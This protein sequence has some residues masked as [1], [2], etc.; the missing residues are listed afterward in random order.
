[1]ATHKSITV[2]GLRNPN[3]DMQKKMGAVYTYSGIYEA[4]VVSA[5]DIQKNGRLKVRLVDSNVN[6][7][8]IPDK[9]TGGEEFLDITVQWSSPFA[10]A[11][12]VEN[13][14]ATGEGVGDEKDPDKAFGGTQKSYGMWMIPPDVGNKVLV[15]FVNGDL[16]RGFVIGCLY[17]S[18]M[19]HMVP[20]IA[21]SKTFTSDDSQTL[22]VPVAEYN[23]ASD[24]ANSVDWKTVRENDGQTPTDNVRRPTHTEH[25]N[26]LKE[27]GL[28]QDKTRGLTSSSARRESP[29][30]VFGI[31]TPDGNQFVMDDGEQQLIRLRTKSG[32]Q[33]LLDETNGNVYIINKKGTGWVEIDNDGKI[34]VW[35]ADSVS[36]RSQK[37]INFRADRDLNIEAGRNVNI[38]TIG[39]TADSF[40]VDV[41]GSLNA[42]TGDKT[43]ITSG[44]DFHLSTTGINHFTASGNTEIK[45]GGNHNETAT[46]IHMNGPAA[47]AASTFGGLTA[48]VDEEGNLFF[49][50][51]KYTRNAEGNRET[52]SV[53]TILTRFPTREP[54]ARKEYTE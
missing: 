12:N 33:L 28:E 23:K 13:T 52:E 32:A 6:Y 44:A 21:R 5:S 38:K 36:V 35:A 39:T 16:A 10:G 49:T 17:Q 3:T 29:S 19:N 45:S 2:S 50:D 20:G 9:G 37:D 43:T 26:G 48:K 15:M 46:E 40:N 25:F 24:E 18:L 51:T 4:V 54:Y 11:T 7:N 41:A 1:M 47:V 30:K 22:E 14:I 42:K 34:D 53:G 31:L 27:Q 8:F